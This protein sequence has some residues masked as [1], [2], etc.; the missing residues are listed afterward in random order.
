V[1]WCCELLLFLLFCLLF[2][3]VLGEFAE[4]FLLFCEFLLELLELLLFLVFCEFS[5][6]FRLVPVVGELFKLLRNILCIGVFSE[7]SKL[8]SPGSWN[9]IEK[10]KHALQV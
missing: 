2:C 8:F 3:L 9:A 1:I 10:T 7:D 5:T 6:D 4:E